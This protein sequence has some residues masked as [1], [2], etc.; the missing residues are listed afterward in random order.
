[1]SKKKL[2]YV[3]GPYSHGNVNR[4]VQKACHAGDIIYEKGGLPFVP[5]LAHMWDMM[6]PQPYEHWMDMDYNYLEL[7]DAIFILPGYSPG[8][9]SEYRRA[10]E[11]NLPIF[12]DYETLEFWLETTATGV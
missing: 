4:N 11:L 3:A 6:S 7:C 2:V 1:M 12:H 9:E 10:Q 5:H 8:A